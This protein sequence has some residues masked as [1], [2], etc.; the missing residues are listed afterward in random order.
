MTTWQQG[1]V[2]VTRVREREEGPLRGSS[3]SYGNTIRR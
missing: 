2:I 1:R 3:R